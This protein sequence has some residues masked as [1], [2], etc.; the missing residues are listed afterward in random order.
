M[1]TTQSHPA[2]ALMSRCTVHR[3]L[4]RRR[5][6]WGWAVCCMQAGRRQYDIPGL[7]CAQT[8][9]FCLPRLG[10]SPS[11]AS[12]VLGDQDLILVAPAAPPAG[13][14]ITNIGLGSNGLPIMVGPNDTT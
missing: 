14:T 7:S 12:T 3:F 1:P 2:Q 8:G 4:Q 6:R 11:P 9:T 13:T 10:L 5:N